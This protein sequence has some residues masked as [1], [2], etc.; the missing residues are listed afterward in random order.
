MLL[1]GILTALLFSSNRS[2]ASQSLR[3]EHLT[4]EDGLS[5]GFVTALAQDSLGFLW[6]GTQDGLNRFDGYEIRSYY[7]DPEDSGSLPSNNVRTLLLDS[8]GTLWVGTRAGGLS[9]Y[10]P[11]TDRFDS[12]RPDPTNPQ[13]LSSGYVTTLYEDRSGVLWVGTRGGG[14][15]RFDRETETFTVYR[16]D[17]EDPTSI[18]RNSVSCLLEDSR[19]QLWIGTRGGGLDRWDPTT[20]GFIHHPWDPDDPTSV[21]HGYVRSLLEDT[22]GQLWVGTTGGVSLWVPETDSFRPWR[23][24]IDAHGAPWSDRVRS[25]VQGSDG[26]IW[27][28]SESIGL[29]RVEPEG[30]EYRLHRPEPDDPHSLAGGATVLL[31]DRTG[32]LWIG[33]AHGVDRHNPRTQ[34]FQSYHRP[35]TGPPEMAVESVWAVADDGEGGL[36]IGDD[37]RGLRHVDAA[38]STWRRWQH[39]KDNPQSLPSDNIYA[40]AREGR[41]VWI[42]TNRG[43]ALLDPDQTITHYSPSTAF[44]IDYVDNVVFSLLRSRGGTLWVGTN[45][46]LLKLSEDR[47]SLELV[48]F[49]PADQE[50]PGRGPAIFSLT[51]DQEGSLW[52]ATF[53]NGLFHFDPNSGAVERF[54]RDLETP[55][56]LPSDRINA[57]HVDAQGVVWAG[58]PLGL[59]R[60]DRSS[61]TFHTLR[62]LHGLPT[63]TVSSI[64]EDNEGNLWLG[65]TNGLARLGPDRTTVDVFTAVDGLPSNEFNQIASAVADDGSLVFGT[66]HG[67][68]TFD[69]KEL[70]PDPIL[71][72]AVLT[73]VRVFNESIPVATEADSDLRSEGLTLPVAASYLEHLTV[74]HQESVLSFE[75][76]ALHFGDP[77]RNRYR[78]QLQGSD[79]RWINTDGRRRVATYTS[80]PAGD[81]TFSVQAAS[82]TGA[83]NEE[84]SSLTLTVR[85]APWKSWWAYT[86]YSLAALGLLFWFVRSQRALA[87][88]ERRRANEE[89]RINH[90]LRR[91]DRLKDEFL[92]NTSHELRTPLHGIVG[93]A[94]SLLDG[95]GGALPVE[96]RSNLKMITSSGHRLSSLIDDVLDFTQ[97]RNQ[98]LDLKLQAVD[99]KA[100]VDVVLTLSR[101]LVGGREL[102][103]VNALSPETPLVVADENRLQQILHNLVGNAIKFTE[104]GEVTVFAETR[105]GRLTLGVRDTGIGVAPE[106]QQAIFESFT[107][108]EADT[109]RLY[110]GTGLGLAVSR[111]LVNLH[112]SELEIDSQPGDGA[113]FSFSLEVASDQ[114]TVCAPTPTSTSELASIT[115][116]SQASKRQEPTSRLPSTPQPLDAHG[117]GFKVL[118]VDDEPVNRQVLV[119]QLSLHEYQVLEA[120]DGPTALQTLAEEDP[121]L[122]LLDV[123]MPRMSGYDVCR[124]IREHTGVG[125]LP[126]I[127]LSA[128]NQVDD[129]VSGLESGGND[130]LTKPIGKAELIARVRT[131]VELLESH[132]DLE[133]KVLERTEELHQ[134]NAQLDRL[135][136]L[137]GLTGIANRRRFDEEIHLQWSVH[138][139][140]GQPLSL[141]MCD[142]DHFKLYNDHHGHQG[143]DATLRSVADV[144]SASTRRPLDL[145]ARYGGEEFVM[146]LP[147]TDSDGALELAR[148][149]CRGIETLAIPHANSPVSTVVTLSIGVGTEIPRSGHTMT[150]FIERC[151]Q[152]LY[153]AKETGRNRAVL[154]D[155]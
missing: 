17:P 75:F 51:E 124:Q 14:L 99:P 97:M 147:D 60:L 94:E 155:S 28:A 69:P 131:H 63:D 133:E 5:Q 137:D 37:G 96:A 141:L 122:V 104:R 36:W 107:Q 121:D 15:N 129:F 25:I 77:G 73:D 18:S 7:F 108:A 38:R 61:G 101:P 81:Y 150:E 148:S 56:S 65:T 76:S 34:R 30:E 89:Q 87:A 68:V 20:Q 130:Y 50:K 144:L 82:P 45:N 146:L 26:A 12:W 103:L 44:N 102:Q 8:R 22:R 4:Q 145:A 128:K 135:A 41:S 67:F 46:G 88:V 42:A 109:A 24:I 120:V 10:D 33:T 1:V 64:V 111:Q 74:G 13:S 139:R 149:V 142:V 85:P 49:G 151:D 127:F 52:I 27:I 136:S 115:S 32:V 80:L 31:E 3:F 29:Y 92:A 55:G 90:E 119:N 9:R 118:V 140:S 71:P 153:R 66:I 19:G 2:F 35:E 110:G 138:Q 43:L 21:R 70:S 6:I 11:R 72:A 79:S 16:N 86:L 143:G 59:H 105:D 91:V 132:R 62:R 114:S 57:V 116:P 125:E 39:Q 93:L 58:S 152:A 54:V 123:M 95:A 134:A 78:Y 40:L 98:S 53:Q 84:G 117:R 23:P 106:Q 113:T 48:Q 47:S 154:A 112:G 126:V 83:W 100:L